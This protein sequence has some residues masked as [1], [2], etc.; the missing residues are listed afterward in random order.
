LWKCFL[1]NLSGWNPMR[2]LIDGCLHRSS[3]QVDFEKKNLRW[4]GHK[5]LALRTSFRGN[6]LLHFCMFLKDVCC[7][8]Q[9]WVSFQGDSLP[10]V[11]KRCLCCDALFWLAMDLCFFSPLPAYP[12]LFPITRLRHITCGSRYLVL[13]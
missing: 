7:N 11:S 3:W 13:W 1:I 2:L 5:R 9:P 12:R 10:I 8:A 4:L 6:S